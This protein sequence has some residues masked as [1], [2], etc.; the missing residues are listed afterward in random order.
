VRVAHPL[1]L[2]RAAPGAAGRTGLWR[3]RRPVVR[4]ECRGC[5]LCWLYCPE[6]VI[7]VVEGGVRIDY[8][9]CKGCG[10]CASVCPF[11]VIVMEDEG[12]G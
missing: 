9:Y 6:G 8:E 7:E 4:G 5:M 1:P 10:V 2:S 11:N 3:T 12:V